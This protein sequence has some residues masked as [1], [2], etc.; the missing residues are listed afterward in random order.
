MPE[1]SNSTIQALAGILGVLL[2]GGVRC[3][4]AQEEYPA[5]PL[6][7]VGGSTHYSLQDRRAGGLI[8]LRLA[9]PFVPL[10][11][12][13]W[14]L[15]P[16]LSYGWYRA[17]SGQRRHV[18]ASEVQLQVQAGTSPV[19]PYA[20]VGGGLALSRGDST[21]A[22][23]RLLSLHLTFSAGVGIRF[24]IAESWGLVGELRVRRL[25]L[26]RGWTRELT[27]GLFAAL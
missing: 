5:A 16:S 10:G 17:D 21:A 20:G 11:T 27:A 14:L 13:H 18:L 8:A 24:A 25:A 22:G 26:F 1:R 23:R 2:V 6:A 19:Q 3:A 12:R 7:L 9:S 15:E 4:W